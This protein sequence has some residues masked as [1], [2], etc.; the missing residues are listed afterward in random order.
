MNG[1]Q[2]AV[3]K[4]MNWANSVPTYQVSRAIG[5][6]ELDALYAKLKPKGVTVSALLAKAVGVT[7]A[8]HPIMN[9][10][11]A[12][13][14]IKYNANIDVAMAVALPDGGLVT[15]TM[16]GADT[17]DLYSISREW[18]DMV[19]RTMEGKLKPSEMGGTFTVSNLG[20]FGVSDFVSIL[21]PGTGAILAV[22]AS[23]P[24][25]VQQ[26]NGMMGM[27]KQMTVTLT[28]DHRHIYGADAAKFLKD[29]AEL[30]ENDMESL[31]F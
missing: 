15:P 16:R 23:T 17:N 24:T 26:K 31:L 8:K 10:A 7:L 12:E 1:M 22:A 28:C 14:A 3:V 29:L 13:D 18:K 11:Y 20:M 30:I 5:T 21:P 4:N 9:A 25:F 27:V 6:S 19:G 2:K